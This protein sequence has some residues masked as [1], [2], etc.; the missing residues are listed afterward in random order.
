[1]YTQTIARL[2]ELAPLGL[3]TD[4]L[5]WRIRRAGLRL[6]PEEIME[7]LAGLADS[8]LAAVEAGGRWKLTQFGRPKS[9]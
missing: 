2:L 5:L 4:Q 1:M 3:S 6:S 9:G 7:P 8:G